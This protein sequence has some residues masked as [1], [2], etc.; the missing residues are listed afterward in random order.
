[1]GSDREKIPKEKEIEQLKSRLS[2]LEDKYKQLSEERNKLA[3][4]QNAVSTT[5]N[6]MLADAKKKVVEETQKAQKLSADLLIKNSQVGE[7]AKIIDEMA[8]TINSDVYV[9]VYYLSK[10]SE[11]NVVSGLNHVKQIRDLIN[12]L[13]WYLKRDDLNISGDLISINLT[14]VL[15]EQIEL[16]SNSLS[17]LRISSDDHFENLQKMKPEYEHGNDYQVNITKE[18][19]SAVGLI[20]KDIVRNAFKNTDEDNPF[21]RAKIEE[22]H[23]E[24]II[25]IT[26]NTLI[27]DDFSDW[28]NGVT[29]MEPEISKSSKVGLR[30][31]K[32]WTDLLNI[33]AKLI[34]NSELNTTTAVLNFPKEI[35]YEK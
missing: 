9:A 35:K 24:V 23:N 6:Q 19:S 20:I 3:H 25:S 12:L 16:V 27:S 14:S 7:W 31:I 18:V 28:F 15:S 30:M 2:E 1:M 21:V 11:T 13:M 29:T 17:T 10:S 22:T 32:K 8:H 26:N 4:S 34:P 33:S 5:I